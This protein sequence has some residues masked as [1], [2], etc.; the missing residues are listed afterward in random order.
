M[1]VVEMW[2]PHSVFCI[3]FRNSFTMKKEIKMFCF[4]ILSMKQFL[5]MTSY[6]QPILKLPIHKFLFWWMHYFVLTIKFCTFFSNCQIENL[7]KYTVGQ[8]FWAL[9]YSYTL[10]DQKF[11]CWPK[12]K[13][14]DRKRIRCWSGIFVSSYSRCSHISSPLAPLFQP[15]SPPFNP[16]LNVEPEDNSHKL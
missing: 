10:L 7:S 16:P 12:K 14:D 11:N 6:Q 15:P 4:F 9:I 13:A 1:I 8:N 3:F 2:Q 5:L